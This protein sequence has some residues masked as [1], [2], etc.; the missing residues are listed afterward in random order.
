MC[1]KKV[2][3]YY[4]KKVK[5]TS[6]KKEKIPTM[7]ERKVKINKFKKMLIWL[8]KSVKHASL[9]LKNKVNFLIRRRILLKSS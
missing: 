2:K 5:L 6:E 8:K 4:F 1:K 3:S 9:R 7:S